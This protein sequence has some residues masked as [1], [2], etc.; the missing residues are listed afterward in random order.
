MTENEYLELPWGMEDTIENLK[1]VG[2]IMIKKAKEADF[3]GRAESD[4]EEIRFDFGRAISAL[5]KQLPEKP[6][7]YGDGYADGKLV[8]DSWACPNCGKGYELECDEYDY[9]PN[10]GQHIDWNEEE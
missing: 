6:F 9:C 5:K 3:D 7:I 8:Y 4:A 1:M 2:S 10:C